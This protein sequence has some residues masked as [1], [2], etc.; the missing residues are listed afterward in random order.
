VTVVVVVGNPRKVDIFGL[1]KFTE[2]Y[3]L[4]DIYI[5]RHKF[6]SIRCQG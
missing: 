1:C 5:A 6:Y 2:I 4:L 3:H